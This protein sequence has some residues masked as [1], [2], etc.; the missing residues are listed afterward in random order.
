MRLGRRGELWILDEGHRAAASAQA[1]SL[2]LP[3]RD[4]SIASPVRPDS[5]GDRVVAPSEKSPPRTSGRGMHCYVK[6]CG[7]V[8]CGRILYAAATLGY[9]GHD[10]LGHSHFTHCNAGRVSLHLLNRPPSDN[11][12]KSRRKSPTIHPEQASATYHRS[13]LAHHGLSKMDHMRN[14]RYG[15]HVD[16]KHEPRQSIHRGHQ[17]DGIVKTQPDAARTGENDS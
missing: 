4:C 17:N 14:V 16:S 8:P 9:L 6:G 15:V 5:L 12:P 11:N 10:T 2:M 3:S 7:S 1:F 13:N